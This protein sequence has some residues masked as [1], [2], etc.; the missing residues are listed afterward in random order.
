[1]PFVQS[2]WLMLALC[3]SVVAAPAA[4]L[5]AAV[6]AVSCTPEGA[7]STPAPDGLSGGSGSSGRF[8]YT[9]S[10]SASIYTIK[11]VNLYKLLVISNF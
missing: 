8:C 11:C 6:A 4:E 3:W 1:M 2:V 7:C 5:S 10:R 9:S